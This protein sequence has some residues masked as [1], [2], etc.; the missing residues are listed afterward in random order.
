M[1]DGLLVID[2]DSHKMENPVVFFDYLDAPYRDRLFSRTDRWGQQRLVVVDFNP[3]TGRND[4]ERVFPQPEGP[5]KGAYCA[6]HP[7]TAIGAVFNRIRLEHMD[8]EGVDAQVIYG[9]MTLSFETLL[10][11]DLAVACMRAYNDY[12]ADDCRGYG[13]RIFPVGYISLADV[14]E[15]VREIHRCV[16]QLGMVGVH[17][18]PAVPVPHPAAPDAFP[19]IRLPKHVSH[20]DFHPVFAAAVA[21]DV[22]L[23]VHG[24]PGVYLPSGIA[25]Q[26]DTFILSHIFGHRNQMQMALAACVFDGVFDRFPTVRMGFLEAGCGWLPDLVHAFHEHWEKRIRD[27]DPDVKVSMVEFTREMLRERGGKDGKLHLLGKARS[28]YDLIAHAERERRTPD[29]D[30]Y[31]FEY[32]H[33][34]HDPTD[35]FR[36]GQV[37]VSF[38]PDDPAPA[39][40]RE[41]LG[42]MGEDVACF[43]GDYGHWDG[44][45]RDCVKNVARTRDY[46]R[47]HLGKLLAGNCLRLYGP[48][49]ARALGEAPREAGQGAGVTG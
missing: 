5:G 37:Y 12:I 29:R 41:A 30:A 25:E 45:L 1:Y 16:E 26:V 43:S 18:P 11:R 13:G 19:M 35:F 27:F 48:R 49:L 38:E 3:R 22:A 47:A 34:D 44:V 6:I 33:L 39:Y 31:I 40:L 8:R 2:A 7:E 24:S 23:G 14:G 42:E 4:L 32:R 21:L 20:P 46:S 28:M 10:D 9:S 36:R 15:A 17:V